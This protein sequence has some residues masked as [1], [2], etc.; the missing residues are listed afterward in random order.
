MVAPNRI[1]EVAAAVGEPARAAML[2]TLMDGRAL[3]ASELARVA[4]VMPQTAS[5]HLARL[6]AA[7]L[8]HREKQGRHQYHRLAD[9]SVA[10]MLEGLMLHA[11]GDSI[12]RPAP[13][14]GP[15]DQALREARTCYDHLA[16]RLGVAVTDAL[17]GRGLVELSAEGGLVTQAGATFLER[18]GVDLAPLRLGQA[19]SGGRVLCRPCLDWSERRPHLAG[20]LG[21]AICTHFLQDGWIARIDGSRAV[22]LTRKGESLLFKRFGIK[23]PLSL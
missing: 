13:R 7:G 2:T 23:K 10:R 14:T 17:V 12:A 3:T 9:A 1:A 15:R 16:G 6:V 21:A 22:R 19:A 18:L 11:A 20:R 8:V 4:G 5:A